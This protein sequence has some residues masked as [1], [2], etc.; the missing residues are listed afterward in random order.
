ME[1]LSRSRRDNVIAG[2]A[3]L[4]AVFDVLKIDEMQYSSGALREGALY[5]LVGRSDH[6]DVCLRSVQSMQGRFN[7]DV[8]QAERVSVC[9]KQLF[10]QV[11]G[12]WGLSKSDWTRLRWAA[13]LHEVG[14]SISH[15]QF[16]KHGEYILNGADM[17]GFTRQQQ[18]GMAFLVRGH[19]RRLRPELLDDFSAKDKSSLLRLCVLLRLAVLLNRGRGDSPPSAVALKVQ[20][21]DSLSLELTHDSFDDN[22]LTLSELMGEA[23]RLDAAGFKLS[24]LKA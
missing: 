16:H 2:L 23:E 18:Q 21:S 4:T 5:D 6:E 14:L 17:P 8:G 12:E 13:E 20:G 9:A 19:R 24:V 10:G 1:W 3:I 22:P 7:V 15:V 11:A